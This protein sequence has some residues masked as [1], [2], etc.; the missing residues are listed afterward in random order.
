MLLIYVLNKILIPR[1]IVK[2]EYNRKTDKI[3]FIKNLFYKNNL[4]KKDLYVGTD[5]R[6]KQVE[7]LGTC[8]FHLYYI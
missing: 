1:L 5:L 4:K 3:S 7:V 2:T 8:S 6:E